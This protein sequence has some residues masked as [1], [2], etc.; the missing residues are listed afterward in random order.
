M[1]EIASTTCD[2]MVALISF[3]NTND[4]SYVRMNT[5]KY[6]ESN[7]NA[8]PQIHHIELDKQRHSIISEVEAEWSDVN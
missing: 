4:S 5:I 7:F 1:I 6:E 8:L 3:S 2:P